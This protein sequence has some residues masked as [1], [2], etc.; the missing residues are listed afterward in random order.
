MNH[1]YSVLLPEK[2]FGRLIRISFW[3]VEVLVAMS[4]MGS[5]GLIQG[6][7]VVS[8]FVVLGNAEA[9]LWRWFVV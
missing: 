1:L 3:E 2:A 5:M 7:W 4:L 6:F 8:W 9:E